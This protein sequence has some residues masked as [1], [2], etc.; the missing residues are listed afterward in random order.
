MTQANANFFL[1]FKKWANKDR[2]YSIKIGTRF[3]FAG[4]HDWTTSTSVRKVNFDLS[5]KREIK[6]KVLESYRPLGTP[7]FKRENNM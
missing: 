2:D 6:Q 5:T 4:D 3:P 1:D 7:R